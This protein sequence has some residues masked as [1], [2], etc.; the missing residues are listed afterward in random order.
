MSKLMEEN[1]FVTDQLFVQLKVK[2]EK[3]TEYKKQHDF[4]TK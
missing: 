1:V 4:V 3:V 2:V